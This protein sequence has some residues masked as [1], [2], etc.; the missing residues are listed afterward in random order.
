[1]KEGLKKQEWIS[2]TTN[3]VIIK[4]QDKPQVYLQFSTTDSTTALHKLTPQTKVQ[5][6][7]PQ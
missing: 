5:K 7:K 4:H 3:C 2:Q 6:N 1:M